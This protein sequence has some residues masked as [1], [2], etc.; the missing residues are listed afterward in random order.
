MGHC[1]E[2]ISKLETPEVK[3]RL[4]ELYG[5]EGTLYLNTYNEHAEEPAYVFK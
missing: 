5:R 3:E 4:A 2:M 1:E